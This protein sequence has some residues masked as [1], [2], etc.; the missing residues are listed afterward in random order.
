MCSSRAS[1]SFLLLC[2]TQLASYHVLRVSA[3]T[4]LTATAL[5]NGKWQT[6]TPYITFVWK[7]YLLTYLLTES[8]PLN[9][10]QKCYSWLR[11]RYNPLCHFKCKSFHESFWA[12][13]WNILVTWIV[14]NMQFIHILT[15]TQQKQQIIENDIK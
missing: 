14:K 11:P 5:V 6:L 3:S 13:G 4:V 1:F 2:T 7:V 12:N 8:K 10:L 15:A 9:Q